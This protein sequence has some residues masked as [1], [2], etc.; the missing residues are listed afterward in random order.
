[1]TKISY[2]ADGDLA[3]RALAIARAIGGLREGEIEMDAGRPR[4]AELNKEHC[5]DD[6]HTLEADMLKKLGP[7]VRCA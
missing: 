7:G 4:L 2:E 5:R 3:T 1:M 6:I